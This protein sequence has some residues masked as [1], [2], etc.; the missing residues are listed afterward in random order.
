[1]SDDGQ[2]VALT[3]GY[4]RGTFTPGKPISDLCSDGS[5]PPVIEY[6]GV[7]MPHPGGGG[8]YAEYDWNC[9]GGV[10]ECWTYFCHAGDSCGPTAEQCGSAANVPS[11]TAPTSNLCTVSGNV[12][13]SLFAPT[14]NGLMWIWTCGIA[15]CDAPIPS[16]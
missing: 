12:V 14:S 7:N 15:N 2:C 11:A 13:P 8:I 5:T 6:S 10:S 16:P 1:L 9:G 4:A 3:C